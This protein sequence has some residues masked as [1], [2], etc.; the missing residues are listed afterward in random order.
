MSISK[1][2]LCYVFFT[3][4][5]T[6]TYSQEEDAYGPLKLDPS[7][8]F[9]K[10]SNGFTYYI[11]HVANSGDKLVM[12][13]YVKTGDYSE[14]PEE[15]D[16]AHAIEHLAFKCA[17]HFSGNIANNTKMR[18]RL[19]MDE[20]D[21]FGGTSAMNTLYYFN[22]PYDRR[23][24]FDTGL[25]WFQDISDL[26]LTPEV[27]NKERGPLRQEKIMK[28]GSNLKE[29]FIRM[30]LE[31]EIMPCRMDNS[32]FF[33]HNKNFDP[34]QLIKFYRKW[35]L[36]N[37][38][39]L[40]LVGDTTRIQDMES[41]VI[42]RFSK[43]ERGSSTI[44][45]EKCVAEY[46]DRQN[47]FVSLVQSKALENSNVSYVKVHLYMRDGKILE[48]RDTWDGLK[49]EV[50][51][52]MLRNVMN[53]RFKVV[54]NDYNSTFTASGMPPHLA[55]PA[56]RIQVQEAGENAEGA[57]RKVMVLLQQLKKYGLSETEWEQQ[58][59][60]KIK[61]LQPDVTENLNYWIGQIQNNYVYGLALPENKASVLHRWLSDLTLGEFNAL[62]QDYMFTMPND[63][64][65]VAPEGV[66]FNEKEVRSW[67]QQEQN[68][69]SGPYIFK[70]IPSQLMDRTKVASLKPVE[71]NFIGTS[72][73]G[74]K[75]F[76]LDNGAKVVL[77][78]SKDL[79]KSNTD[80]I[81]LHGFS[82]YGASCFKKGDY[83]SAINAPSIIQ[84][85]GLGEMDKFQIQ[86]FLDGTSI[87]NGLSPY[88]DYRETGFK[89]NASIH[90]LENLLQLVYLH[91]TNPRKDHRAFDDWKLQQIKRHSSKPSY[92]PILEDFNV[93]VREF[94]GDRSI[95]PNGTPRWE[96]IS[97]TNFDRSYEI[98]NQLYGD[99]SDFT[100]LITGDVTVNAI[101]PLIQKYLGSI[102]RSGSVPGCRQE[103]I[104]NV[105]L[106]K[107]PLY[108]EFSA[109][110]LGA[111]Y[112]LK[113]VKYSMKFISATQDP[114]D[115]Q[116]HIKV[117]ILG[118]LL[119]SISKKL[120][121][122]DESAIYDTFATASFNRELSSY[123][124]TMNLDCMAQDLDK[125]R[126]SC[127]ELVKEV[128]NKSLQQGL[129][130]EVI[131]NKMA[132]LQG[133]SIFQQMEKL[134]GYYKFNEPWLYTTE[135]E[136]YL[137]SLKIED[138]EVTAKKYLRDENMMEF[139]FKN[140]RKDP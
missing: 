7:I 81:Y 86:G 9:G 136:D 47:Q 97:R 59:N 55:F 25:Q 14:A 121:Y 129:F 126:N 75:E 84:N 43:L 106:P 60:K 39:A 116:E 49:R 104:G 57:I 133:G 29:H 135:V 93:A 76:V 127:K 122:V 64:A 8:R 128:G 48:Q 66:N 123:E 56:Y 27:I 110:E 69:A 73:F 45:S 42:K 53:G 32:N 125:I 18:S 98:Y 100:F 26:H 119:S 137:K 40:V 3:L 139:V 91:F 36:S 101:L 51:W 108:R 30:R 38:M 62:L 6:G 2:L 21:V 102:P 65:I 118:A 35:Y 72:V 46:L 105:K 17:K 22:V 77:L 20:N 85:A 74:A 15:L 87:R 50:V 79:A 96:G 61:E 89:G 113:G 34:E 124:I 58:K 132:K 23:D 92:D 12:R 138:I 120:R 4:N 109:R 78:N 13:F 82:P 54:G 70:E 52:S 107:G 99:P 115:W 44:P 88:I 31:S 19:G 83:F 94:I 71:S 103:M 134:Y 140:G 68:R 67:I 28:Q 130:K 41:N 1:V 90:D 10:L 111:L 95:A 112:A 24:A 37:N 11:K 80:K 114:L 5:L 131:I 117:E 33:E 63:I 16:F